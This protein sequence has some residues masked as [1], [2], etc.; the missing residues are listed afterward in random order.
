MSRQSFLG[1]LAQ[2][3]TA[4]VIAISAAAMI[5]LVAMVGG[6]V[7]ASRYYM[8]D[9]RLQAA[10]DAGAL[11]A[12]RAMGKEDW[13]SEYNTIANNFFD[14]NYT[15]GMFGIESLSRTYNGDSDGV[16]TGTV[17]GNLPTSLMSIF[18]Y[19]EFQLSVT[20]E[21]DI[22]IANTDIVF[23]LD[24]TGSMACKPD[25]SSCNSGSESKIEALR[26]AAANF[27]DTV[28]SATGDRAQVRYGIVPYSNAVNVGPIIMDENSSWM[29]TQHSYQSRIA[30]FTTT[31]SWENT[32]DDPVLDDVDFQNGYWYSY[33]SYTWYTG[34]NSSS[35]AAAVPDDI[36]EVIPDDF[37]LS[38]GTIVSTSG[39]S[40]RT[41]TYEIDDATIE[42]WD[43]FTYYWGSGWCAI[44]YYVYE[45]EADVTYTETEELVT[46]TVFDNYTYASIGTAGTGA[47]YEW[48]TVDLTDLYDDSN[49]DLPI[50]TEGALTPVSWNGCI[51]EAAT[52]EG[53]TSFD[54]IPSAAKDLDIDLVPASEDERW[55][56][57]LNNAY[58]R[59]YTSGGSYTTSVLT[60][61]RNMSEHPTDYCPKAARKLDPFDS[62]SDL[63][64]YLS[65]AN[66]FEARGN[67]YHDIGM[68]WGARLISPDGIFSADNQVGPDGNGI[69]RHIV[70]MTDG[71]LYP[72]T[73][74]SYTPYGVEY[75]DR[76]V[77]TDGN[78]T[79][80]YNNHA[81]RFQAACEAARN[82]NISVWVVA[83]GTSLTSNLT[84]CASSGRAYHADNNDELDAAF[85]EIAEKI[86]QLRL[87]A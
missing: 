77:T 3:A 87:T 55:K 10:C 40:P 67:T 49:I 25:G 85:N 80:T 57:A 72:S 76:R 56:P 83:F 26:D 44:G 74:S 36:T 64:S 75:W 27:Y 52:D 38:G 22:N 28:D 17:T 5:P 69:S 62:K 9:S 81:A 4:N 11:A 59:R 53:Q 35:C 37:D 58:I 50:G 2:D 18:G 39:S 30:N 51:E 43:G 1:R 13:A 29:A 54:P 42:Y 70:F 12:R 84:D 34:Y 78:W 14:Q 6:G 68:I 73:T 47:T 32:G 45:Y 86:A 60:T 66:G 63:E 15:D 24:V 41:V 23:V 46:E 8:T 7:D 33:P 82:K 48:S 61:T 79:T 71:E 65:A 19:E 31:T 21:A 16:V 20:C